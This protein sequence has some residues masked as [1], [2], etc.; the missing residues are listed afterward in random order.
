[1]LATL[2]RL[3]TQR[4]RLAV[5]ASSSPAPSPSKPPNN[6][7]ELPPEPPSAVAAGKMTSSKKDR[8]RKI[9]KLVD[10]V[11][12]AVDAADFEKEIEDVKMERAE[13]AAG[14]TVKFARVRSIPS[15][16]P[17]SL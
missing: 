6:P 13:T 16:P 3:Q 1:M 11:Q 17:S 10:R 7:F 4:D 12:V 15:V 14:K 5:V 8:K 2:S 9:Q